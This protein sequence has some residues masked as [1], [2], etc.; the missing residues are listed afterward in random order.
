M[1]SRFEKGHGPSRWERRQREWTPAH[2][3]CTHQVEMSACSQLCFSF[4]LSVRPDL[5][6]IVQ[7]VFKMSSR[8]NLPSLDT[9][10]QIPPG[11]CFLDGSV[12]YQGSIS[13][14]D[15]RLVPQNTASE[16]SSEL[17]AFFVAARV[18]R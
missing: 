1:S 4:L 15:S 5:V 17:S 14:Q 3:I 10:S 7:L 18:D 8:L 11:V 12:D 16:K 2:C 6:G 9:P 13:H